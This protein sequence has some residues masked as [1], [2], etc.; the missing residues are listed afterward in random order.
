MQIRGFL[1]EFL[2]NLIIANTKH[3]SKGKRFFI[4]EKGKIIFSAKNPIKTVVFVLD[5]V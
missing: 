1:V 5:V 3:C 4:S 2:I